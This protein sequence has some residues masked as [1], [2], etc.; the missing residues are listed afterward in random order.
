MI[1]GEKTTVGKRGEILAKKSLCN[2][3]DIHPGDTIFIEATPGQLLIRKVPKISDILQRPPIARVTAQKL[4]KE[5][6]EES[7]RQEN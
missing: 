4:E 6:D 2:A 1:N 7:R 3:A 5:L